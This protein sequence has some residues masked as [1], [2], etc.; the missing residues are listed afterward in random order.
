MEVLYN[1]D[2]EAIVKKLFENDF[3]SFACYFFTILR[4]E[5]FK[6]NWHHRWLCSILEKVYKGELKNVIINISPGSSK[7]CIVS[8]LFPA[9]CYFKNPHCRF[10]TTSYS[11]DLVES[12]SVSIKDIIKSPEFQALKGGLAFRQDSNKKNEWTLLEN[13]KSVGEFFTA[14][15]KGAL[16][17]RRA[18]Y[19]ERGYFTGCIIVDD[20]I[21]PIDALSETKR[22]EINGALENTLGSR[23]AHSDVP[24]VMI[25]QRLDEDDPTGFLLKYRAADKWTHIK[26][27]AIIDT[28]YFDSLPDYIKPHAERFLKSQLDKYGEASY[29][30][31]KEPLSSLKRLSVDNTYVFMSQY[32][33]EPTPKGGTLIQIKYFQKVEDFPKFDYIKIFADTAFGVK[34]HNDNSCFMAIGWHSGLM[35]IID[36]LKGRWE[37]PQ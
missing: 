36:V 10:L 15:I 8:I 6:S 17:G 30:E 26:I 4:G 34:K 1:N 9:W 7:S 35:Y 19:M 22:N 32:Q 24:T 12:N 33:Q 18:G 16:T 14:S 5:E 28:D 25:M 23:K 13:G 11:D 29:W 20:P 27:P 31:F 37:A 21:K 2:V 3:Y